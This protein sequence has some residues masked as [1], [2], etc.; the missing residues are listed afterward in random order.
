MLLRPGLP[1]RHR[2]PALALD[3]G[4]PRSPRP[5]CP[6][7]TATATCCPRPPPHRGDHGPPCL[8][9]EQRRR[10]GYERALAAAGILPDPEIDSRV[11]LRHRGRCDA[12]GA[13]STLPSRRLRSSRSTTTSRSARSGRP[14]AR[15]PRAR[16]RRSS[17][18]TTSSTRD[19]HAGADDRSP[20]AGGDGPDRRQPADAPA[21][22]AARG[23]APR[24]A[25]DAIGRPRLHRA[26]ADALELVSE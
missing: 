17:A 12:A 13:C 10:S 1:L 8:A 5:T 3:D 2:R 7:P 4:F 9:R 6:A 21:R 14:R 23:D 19:R 24:R 25:R 15:P 26:A 20:A 16:R 11:R 18:S 22:A